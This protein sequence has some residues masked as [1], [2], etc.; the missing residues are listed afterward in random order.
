MGFL[1][2][3]YIGFHSHRVLKTQIARNIILHTNVQ[4]VQV[5]SMNAETPKESRQQH[6][7]CDYI[8]LTIHQK[9]LVPMLCSSQGG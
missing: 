1:C 4:K 2:S 7:A 9:S 3:R 6:F 8:A 5:L